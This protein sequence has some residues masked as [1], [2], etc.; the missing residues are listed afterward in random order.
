MA[1]I[2]GDTLRVIRLREEA[3]SPAAN[4]AAAAARDSRGVP[5]LV[6]RVVNQGAM[7]SSTEHV[8]LVSPA[9]LDGAEAEGAAVSISADVAR[10]V[11]VVIIGSRVPAVGD[12]LVA[13]AIGGRWVAESGPG[14]VPFACWP[15]NIPRKSL[16]VS[17]VNAMLGNGSATLNYTPP[18]QWNTG[19]THGL[20]YS[21]S[22]PGSILQFSVT[23][24]LSG[25]CPSGQQQACSSSGAPPFA[26]RLTDY[27]CSP[28]YLKY[29][30]SG[31][32]C[33]VLGSSGY[34]SFVVTE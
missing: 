16:T 15:C 7:P 14:Q 3:P 1:E 29:V 9:L 6:G 10:T 19:C 2:D 25:N 24:F 21:L 34:S 27:S 33:P 31:S 12:A 28:L 22:C 11:P 13:L 20:V 32:G 8:F 23:Y 30:I 26:L 5:R 4:P 18:G 17:W